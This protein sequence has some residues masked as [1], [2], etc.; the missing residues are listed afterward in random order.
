[1]KEKKLVMLTED[2]AKII[3]R[4]ARRCSASLAEKAG[5]IAMITETELDDI[6]SKVR[7][8]HLHLHIAAAHFV[9]VSPV[10]ADIA[11]SVNTTPETI[12]EWANLPEWKEAVRGWGWTGD[13]QPRKSRRLERIPVPLQEAFLL[14]NVFQKDSDVRFVTY[15]GFVDT[16]VKEVTRFDIILVDGKPL[17]K[18]DVIIAFPRD[19]MPFIREGVK[20]R[21]ALN[22]LP[23]AYIDRR[24]DR[25]KVSVVARIGDLVECVTR[26]GLVIHGENIWV[27]RYNIVLRV[28]GQKGKGGKVILVYR[29]A[30][31]QFRVLKQKPKRHREYHDGWDDEGDKQKTLHLLQERKR[32]DTSHRDGKVGMIRKSNRDLEEE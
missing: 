13:P 20:N 3:S 1:M 17:R 30:L 19:S 23:L 10:A 21:E 5:N 14:T 9:N 32:I 7:E 22:A 24:R 12:L 6:L 27:S 15:A 18:I 26:N 11:K 29:H 31:L 4:V 25:P 2:E 8:S 16:R 28:G